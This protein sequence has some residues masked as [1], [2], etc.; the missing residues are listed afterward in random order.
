MK[1]TLPEHVF[2]CGFM[3]AGKSTIGKALAQKLEQP[4]YDLDTHIEA[5]AGQSI[6]AIFEEEDEQHFRKKEREALRDIIQRE[7][8]I[9]ALG[10]GALQNQSLVD[11]IKTNGL[12][13]FIHTP[14][15]RILKRV[16]ENEHRPMLWDEK[17]AMKP[18]AALEKDIQAL[19]DRRLPLYE[20]AEITVNSDSFSSKEALVTQLAK[21]I[22]HH[23]AF[24]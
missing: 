9:I 4:F 6:P 19:Y 16:M 10:G 2:I 23:A 12:L 3:G 1:E 18:A 8:G 20:Q 15:E 7:K 22:D 17:G 11:Y 21:K 5:K 14:V 13:I 24:H